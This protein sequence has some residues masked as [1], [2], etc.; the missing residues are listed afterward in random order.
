MRQCNL[1]GT[2]EQE[3]DLLRGATPQQWSLLV[4]AGYAVGQSAVYLVGATRLPLL[5]AEGRRATL[6]EREPRARVHSTVLALHS[7]F[8]SRVVLVIADP[9]VVVRQRGRGHRR[10]HRRRQAVSLARGVGHRRPTRA[11]PP[12]AD[13]RG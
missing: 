1:R 2:S 10:P 9:T 5:L 13:D 12:T 7:D 8:V 4:L 11:E 3:S 6:G